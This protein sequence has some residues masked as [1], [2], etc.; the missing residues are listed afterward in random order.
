[1][2]VDSSRN[3]ATK[4]SQICRYSIC[5]LQAESTRLRCLRT[6]TL[7][8]R[9]IRRIEHCHRTVVV[10]EMKC[11]T[12]YEFLCA[13]GRRTHCERYWGDE[14]HC[15][16]SLT[17]LNNS[18]YSYGSKSWTNRLETKSVRKSTRSIAVRE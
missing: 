10:K 16:I 11:A 14:L 7:K 17:V 6:H 12:G 8:I 4:I 1:M 9:C 15:R 18:A 3:P 2:K 5:V 13:Q